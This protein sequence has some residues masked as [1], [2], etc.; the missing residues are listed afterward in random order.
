MDFAIALL[1]F[2]VTLAVYFN[3]ANN[4]QK[5]EKGD[6][7]YMIN[8]ATA[9]SSSLALGGYPNDWDNTSVIRIGIS[10]EQKLNSSKLKNF[11]KLDYAITKRKFA[12][13]YDYFVFFV[14]NKGEV[15]NINGICGVGYP[16][17]NVSYNIKSAYYYS[18]EDDSFLK[19]FINE[20]FNA[21]IYFGDNP[22]DEDDIDSLKSNITKY[23][24]LIME[25]PLL[26][27]SAYNDIKDEINNFTSTG[28][29]LMI[30][31]ELTTAQG[32]DLVGV[33]F[34]KKA[35]Q[36]T[37][38]RN[39][40]VNSTDPYLSVNIGQSIVFAQAYY[41]ENKSE[42]LEFKQIASFNLDQKNAISKWKY[43]NGSVYFFS[44][45]DIT[46]FDGNFV[47]AV[48]DTIKG[49]IAGT[50]SP[51]NISIAITPKKLV[52]TERYLNYNSDIIKMIV[53]LWQ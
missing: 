42:S 10:N 11:K 41:V 23:N 1:I 12:T 52:K 14:N 40:T 20:S 43:G 45:F 4:F 34:Y 49:F 21:D 13:T 25:H 19:D 39:S 31:G 6:I 8:E 5:Q 38:D 29:L 30:S 2:V 3:Y 36:S 17:I 51:V 27:T 37:S 35:G 9:I 18:A 7:D 53:Y 50:C 33:D 47:E 16:L 15:L 22:S 48:E 26:P 46:A 32:K 44:D 28:G 24:F